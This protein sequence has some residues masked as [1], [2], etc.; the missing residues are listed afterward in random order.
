MSSIQERDY[1]QH[2]FTPESVLD[3]T[4]THDA[5]LSD[6][7]RP[8]DVYDPHADFMEQGEYILNHFFGDKILD[9][10]D[11][12][13]F[14]NSSQGNSAQDDLGSDMDIDSDSMTSSTLSWTF[15]HVDFDNAGPNFDNDLVPEIINLLPDE[16]ISKLLG[17]KENSTIPE[18]FKVQTS[19]PHIADKLGTFNIQN[20]FD[21]DTAAEL[22]IREEM[23]F[24]A[25]QE[26]FA[27]SKMQEDSWSAFQKLEMQNARITSYF[28]KYQVIMFDSWKWGGKIIQE[29]ESFAHGRVT[30]IAFDL[31]DKQR[32][33]I[34]SV[35][36]STKEAFA[37]SSNNDAQ[38]EEDNLNSTAELID[39]IKGNIAHKYPGICT[40]IMGDLQETLSTN[41]RDNIGACRYKTPSNGIL[42]MLQSS[43][44]SIVRQFTEGKPYITRIG[45]EGGRGIDH[46]LTPIKQEFSTWFVD[47]NI[48]RNVGNSYFP[49]DH[50][51]LICHMDRKDHNNAE[52]GECLRSYDYNKIFRIKLARTGSNKDELILDENQFK[53]CEK[54]R[55]QQE[56]YGKI[57]KLTGDTSDTTDYLIGDIEK[58]ASSLCKRL[59]YEG[60][61]Q[62]VDGSENKLV[63][64]ADSHAV[65][66]AHI[67]GRFNNSI[68]DVMQTLD[69]VKDNC[70]ND[71]AANIRGRLRKRKGFKHFDNLPITT[72]LRYLRG[73]LQ[74]KERSA[75][76]AILWL[77][78]RE[79]RTE[80]SHLDLPWSDF[81]QILVQMRDTRELSKK[82]RI[83]YEEAMLDASE[84]ENHVESIRYSKAP[85]QSDSNHRNKE[86][87]YQYA[88]NELPFVPDIIVDQINP[89][90]QEANCEQLFGSTHSNDRFEALLECI[91]PWKDIL[92]K[93]DIESENMDSAS[94]LNNANK[95]LEECKKKIGNIASKIRDLQRFYK[96]ATLQ[97]FLDT[98]QISNFTRK[99]LP[100]SR[101]APATHTQIWD[102]SLD[103]FRQCKNEAE[104]MDATRDFHGK[105]M[106]NSASKEACAF[107]KVKSMGKLG[108]RGITL[109]PDRIIDE[110]D[111]SNLVHDGHKLPPRIKKA[112]IKAHGPHTRKLFR[113]PQLDHKELYY[114]FFLLDNKGN[115]N[116]A[117][118]VEDKF[119]KAIASVPSKARHDGF[120]L[121]VVGRFG[122]RWQLLLL[123]IIKLLLIMRYVPESL[124]VIARFPIPKPGKVNEYRPISLCNDLYCFLNGVIT[125]FSSEG[126]ERA[127]ILHDGIVAYR[128]GRGCHSLVTIEQCFREDCVAGPWPVVQL[129]ED[130]E[131]FFDRV[132]VEIILA[133]MRVNGFPEQGFLEFKASAMGPKLVEIITSKGRAFAKFICGLE[134]GNPDSPTIANLVIKFKHDIWDAV[135][136]EIKKI[137]RR[138]KGFKDEK[139]SFNIIDP[140][141]GV[142]MLCKIGY[143]DDNSK[144]IRIEN[145]EDLVRLVEYYLQL[146]GDLSM[147]TKIGR[148]GSKCDIQFFNLSAEMT[149][150]LEKCMSIAWSFK[151]DA[152]IEEEV[153]FRVCMKEDQYEKLKILID[154]TN[155]ENLEK[156]RWDK[157]INSKAHRH[158]G[159]IGKLSGSTVET[160]NYFLQKME[161]RL[162]QLNIGRMDAAPQ[163]KC[164]NMLVN[165][166]HSYIP[167]QANHSTTRLTQFDGAV[168]DTI[169]R[170]NGI[171][172]TDCKHRIFLPI[173]EGGLGI[174]SALEIDITSVCRELEI[175]SNSMSLDSY[176]FRTRIYDA[177]KN[178][179]VNE[180]K[181]AQFF[182]HAKQAIM[183]LG[184]YGIHLRDR[185]DGIVNDVLNH[186]STLT[187]YV[188]I[189]H[190]NYKDGSTAHSI[191]K[192]KESNLELAFGGKIHKCALLL[193][194]NDWK[195]TE[196]IM[197]MDDDS[198]IKFK[199]MIDVLPVIQRTKM[200]DF[201]SL[202]SYWEWVNEKQK[203]QY[204]VPSANDKWIPNTPIEFNKQTIFSKIDWS[205]AEKPLLKITK[206]HMQ[207]F[208]PA[209]IIKNGNSNQ[210][211]IQSENKYA[212]QINFIIKKESPIIIATDGALQIILPEQKKAASSATVICCLDIREGES[213]ASGEWVN[214]A[215]IPL[216]SRCSLLPGKIGAEAVDIASAEC[217]A[218]LMTELSLPSFL[219]RIYLTDSEAVRDQTLQAR[220]NVDG[221]INRSFIRSNIG[222]IGKC[223]MGTLASEIH[224]T[225]LEQTI[226]EASINNPNAAE[227]IDDLKQRNAAFLKIAKSWTEK[228]DSTMESSTEQRGE[229]VNEQ[230][231]TTK[232]INSW[233][234]DYFDGDVLRC[235]LKVNSHQ[236]NDAGLKILEKPRYKNLIPNLCVL[237]AN[238]IA[239][240]IADLP[241]TKAFAIHELCDYNVRNPIS[242][243]RFIITSNGQSID[244][245]VSAVLR[246]SFVQ[247]RIK[248]IKTKE[249]QG[250]LWRIKESINMT[251][252][253][254]NTHK[255]YLRSL[256]GLSRTHT[257]SIYKNINYKQGCKLEQLEGLD[258]E[259]DKQRIK[260]MKQKELTAFLSKCSW[261]PPT[262]SQRHHHGNRLHALLYCAHGNLQHFRNNVRKIINEEICNMIRMVEEYTSANNAKKLVRD[263]SSTYL[264]LQMTQEGRLKKIPSHLNHAYIS[265]EALQEKYGSEDI[266]QCILSTK[267]TAAA[268][269]FG[270]IPQ[271]TNGIDSDAK[272]GAADVTWLG[273][274]P[275]KI[276]AIIKSHRAIF[277]ATTIHLTNKNGLLE[278]FD[279][280]WKLIKGLIL[281]LAAGMH[282]II[283][284][285]SKAISG[286]LQ[287]KHKLEAYTITALKKKIK[288][289]QEG[290]ATSS[291]KTFEDPKCIPCSN[292]NEQHNAH[293]IHTTNCSGIT[294]A[295]NK[296]TWTILENFQT[297]KIPS[298]KKHCLRCTRHSSAIRAAT[299]TLQTFIQD[300][301]APDKKKFEQVLQSASL[302]KPCYLQFMHLLQRHLPTDKQRVRTKY[303]NK[304]RVS[305]THKTMCRVITQA[306]IT[307]DTAPALQFGKTSNISKALNEILE[308]S[309]DKLQSRKLREKT[310]AAKVTR[311]LLRST[312][313]KKEVTL[314]EDD[315]SEEKSQNL[316]RKIQKTEDLLEEE[317]RKHYIREALVENGYMSSMA[318]RRAIEVFRHENR[319][320][321]FFANP[322]AKSIL[323]G[324]APSQGWRRA[325]RIFGS[326]Q[327]IC[328]KPD[329]KYFIP[330]FEGEDTA[331]HWTVVIVHKRGNNRR[332]YILDSL[333]K[334]NLKSP[335]LNTIKD[336]FKCARSYFAWSAPACFQQTEVEC[337]ARAIMHIARLIEE[338]RKGHPMEISLEKA[339]LVHIEEDAYSAM[340]IRESAAEIIGRFERNMWTN[341]IRVGRTESSDNAEGAGEH[342]KKK[343]R[344]R[345]RKGPKTTS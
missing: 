252:D 69:L 247:E 296:P 155:L 211:C 193:Q 115:M 7:S 132:S 279:D 93:I 272:I 80:S 127:R 162:H 190:P 320:D 303:T 267:H 274:I 337:G 325:A 328:H 1:Y 171:T 46:I 340:D 273:L 258:D 246:R 83:L 335:I 4:L 81:I 130:E 139:Y 50:S 226:C 174:S 15:E 287:K 135:T 113:P 2:L 262:C 300:A 195:I 259:M 330:I 44:Q 129:D 242:P 161:N 121:A 10:E 106:G 173:E 317:R 202:F 230:D 77:K 36:A 99:M 281:G 326:Q 213:I 196:T 192:G 198:A 339:S 140:I 319:T 244:K 40:I 76:Q 334:A 6:A 141:D 313:T 221:E 254:L 228:E 172:A 100:Q 38:N 30:S 160:S 104:E 282:K 292:K 17:Q 322:E 184:K 237:N 97:Y 65:E 284:S 45:R 124:K 290:N 297:N 231:E 276:N 79:I 48:H 327:A 125:K 312:A 209:D 316:K 39:E 208:Q 314:V 12:S 146:A 344:R 286:K 298:G 234:K 118:S 291:D 248:R 217:H 189:G 216:C 203:P 136:G 179:K 11:N 70:Q 98:N 158:L 225:T 120:Q 22:F 278:N 34:I 28:T 207:L 235:F 266:L 153:P 331:G 260:E 31:G 241:L 243:L 119:W 105:W 91:S 249:T 152:P 165:T 58:R 315:N 301:T 186:F 345:R 238:H 333:G 305:D 29:F 43:H 9:T 168:A 210:L 342:H 24:L 51:L 131:K 94:F 289:T 215:V 59:W 218:I 123:K 227:L 229:K 166:I 245:H 85:K 180:D 108:Q 336:L 170:A 5:A 18:S 280:K 288:R 302:T 32:I 74:R 257:R 283:G 239:D 71:T 310:A 78:E 67:I 183:K 13:V 109:L 35:Y 224:L 111:V 148:K 21:H 299:T 236:L 63:E 307:D 253:E 16:E 188:S 112:F 87:T 84:R 56:L 263:I 304:S 251:W 86:A 88:S 206:E 110:K 142:V 20:K 82:S 212:K 49:S 185:N 233:R 102:P 175:V 54:F 154:Y 250:L 201:N 261:C 156:L 96:Q 75:K 343:K 275:D 138:Q 134:Q 90:L 73:A 167:L 323:E 295:I 219:P 53:A 306:Y 143:C 66:I 329:G 255:G 164:I 240:K 89:W 55:N 199:E 308:Q 144:F 27:H 95:V 220:Q 269:L 200:H 338:C 187:R 19:P 8:Q 72:K 332:G 163:R 145:E 107:A 157:I 41:D 103:D 25:L 101:T 191:G 116:E 214:R 321:N 33:N 256:L 26:P 14:S 270:L 294:C 194:Q 149:I 147:V 114:P 3:E 265:L 205:S 61:V 204:M 92:G 126:I 182:N 159:M 311:I 177:K 122:R 117:E 277:K 268:E 341:P 169:R 176:A 60:L 271:H 324:W 222:G 197:G 151:H 47:A 150:K 137:F 232:V 178:M 181:D 318:I 64:I 37:G 309:E 264:H 68:K 62:K 128:R 133:A 285:T 52:D 223:I 293:G 23:T 42:K 57:Q